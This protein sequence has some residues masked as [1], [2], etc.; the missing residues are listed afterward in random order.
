MEQGKIVR[1][2][3]PLVV[4]SG[5]L[6]AKMYDMV[7]IG[8]LGL[9]GEIIELRED[10]AFIQV[11]EDTTGIGPDEPVFLTGRPLSVELGPGLVSSI[12]DGIQRPLDI[13]R[14]KEGN[15]V[16]R[17]IEVPPLDRKKKWNF[18]PLVQKGQEV[19]AGDF[20]GEIEETPLI[21]HRIMVPFGAAGKIEEIKSGKFTVEEIVTRIGV[22]RKSWDIKMFQTWSIRKNREVRE[23]LMPVENEV[24]TSFWKTRPGM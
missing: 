5:C 8:A 9:I 1:V 16:T 15:F 20:L 3:G 24:A 19:Q 17:G 12:Y 10:R 6:G 2:A 11:Y 14:D 22:E 18:H 4:A 7:K 13:I 21:K 23:R